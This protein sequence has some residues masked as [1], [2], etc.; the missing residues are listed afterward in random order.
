MALDL[1]DALE[2]VFYVLNSGKFNTYSITWVFIG[3]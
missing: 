2:N 1:N 3:V